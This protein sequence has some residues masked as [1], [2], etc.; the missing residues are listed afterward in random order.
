MSGR[1]SRSTLMLTNSSFI[2]AAVAVVLEALV[3][4]H[5]APVTGRVADRQQDRP[6]GCASPPPA[7]PVPTA[8]SRPDCACAAADRA[9]SRGRDGFRGCWR[10]RRSTF[11][12]PGDEGRHHPERAALPGVT[13]FGSARMGRQPGW[14][15]AGLTLA[16]VVTRQRSACR[17]P[18]D[19]IF[20]LS[21][22]RPP[23]AVAVVRIS[24]PRAGDALHRADRPHSGAAPR[25]ARARARSGERRDDRRGAGAVVPGA[26]QRDRRGHGRAATA[27]RARGGR[28]RARGARRGSRAVARPRRASSPAAPSRTASSISPGSR[29]SPTSS[30]PTPRRSGARPCASSAAC[31]AIAPRPGARG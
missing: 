4:H 20:A 21:S 14:R 27:R 13:P 29:A 26:E 19:T 31:W 16:R 2:T 9:R 18:P 17:C 6:V 25:R 5:V 23:A 10:L 22:G 1:S 11:R 3:R 28:R 12:L 24:G 15:G 8:T 30:P 7:P